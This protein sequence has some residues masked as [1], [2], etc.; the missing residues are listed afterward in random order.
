MVSVTYVR[1]RR[2]GPMT[3]TRAREALLPS[4]RRRIHLV[5]LR[6]VVEQQLSTKFRP[7]IAEPGL[8]LLA[9]VSVQADRM[10]VVARPEAVSARPRR[11]CWRAS[12]KRVVPDRV[13]VKLQG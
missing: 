9:H 12:P 10:R 3:Q 11:E 8:D 1:P 2:T 13:R 4:G 7:G 6:R 5:E